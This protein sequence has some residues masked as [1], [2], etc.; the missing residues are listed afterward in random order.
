MLVKKKQKEVNL[1]F[2]VVV[3]VDGG[4]PSPVGVGGMNRE[5]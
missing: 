5:T 4:G 2:L 3:R 1:P